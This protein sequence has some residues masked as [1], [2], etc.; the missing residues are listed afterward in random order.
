[1]LKE[2]FDCTVI[3]T[4]GDTLPIWARWQLGVH[5]SLLRILNSFKDLS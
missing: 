1:M 2:K 3:V 5:A 4:S